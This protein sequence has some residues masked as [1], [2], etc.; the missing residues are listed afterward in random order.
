MAT[1]AGSTPLDFAFHIHTELGFRCV[2]GKVNGKLV[3]LDTKLNNG[4][5]VEILASK[6][7]RGPS[8]D[9]LNPDL[10]YMNTAGAREKV[11]QWFRKQERTAN[12]QRG[13][14]LLHEIGLGPMV[15]KMDYMEYGGA[16]LIGVN[17]NIIISHGRS[18]A[19]AIKSAIRLAIETAG[20]NI[21]QK[22]REAKLEKI[23]ED[24]LEHANRA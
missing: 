20:Q 15:K 10:G 11:R 2:G 12:V 14:D 8:L 4:D 21:P 9:W 19:K 7:S 23:K 18:Q 17:G 5:T 24:N 16:C 13:R 3:S 1:V 6:A 22:I